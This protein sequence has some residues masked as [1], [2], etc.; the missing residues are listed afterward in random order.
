M[1]HNPIMAGFRCQPL[2]SNIPGSFPWIVVTILAVAA[3]MVL[4]VPPVDL[5][6]KAN[7]ASRPPPALVETRIV[8][9]GEDQNHRS[10]PFTVYVLAQEL[11]WKLE[12]TEDLEG[13]KTILSPELT[14]AINHAQDVFCVGTASFEG[15]SQA[16][17][18]RAA[19]R[20]GKLAQ[21]VGTVIGKPGHTRLFTLNAGQYKG[22]TELI[23]SYQRKA[24]ILVTG[25][26]DDK[27]DLGEG[28]RSGLEQTQQT[29]PVVYSLLHH[30]SRSREWLKLAN[31][32]A[33][34]IGRGK[35]RGVSPRMP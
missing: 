22:P 18:A 7:P 2:I 6:I 1:R 12:S 21:W 24:I 8:T 30:Y 26:H 32:P 10:L 3:A 13:E 16:E 4:A 20:A 25:P 31:G 14:V 27:V 23:S 29:S 9:V 17:E 28:L 11:S 34:P 15:G 35:K 33:R 19:Q 5:S